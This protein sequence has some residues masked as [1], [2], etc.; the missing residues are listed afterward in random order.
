MF[1]KRVAGKCWRL[2]FAVFLLESFAVVAFAQQDITKGGLAGTVTDA[3]GG[4]VA[5]ATV[6]IDGQ[7][8][9]RK[10]T[11]GAGGQFEAS[12]LAPG[13]YIVKAEATGFKSISIPSVT[14]FVGKTATLKLTLQVGDVSEVIQVTAGEAAVDLSS[15][16]VSSNLNDQ[17][18]ENLPLQRS[19]T[20]LFYLAPGVA[21]G[22]GT[23]VNNPSISGASGL[24]N[25]YVADGVNITDSAFGGLGVFS[26]SYGS[27]GTAI[28]TTFIQE[29]Q[30]KTGGFEPR[31]GQAEGG[32]I[33]IITKSGTNEYHGDVF[34]YIQPKSFEANRRQRDTGAVNKVGEVLHPELYEAGGDFSGPVPG[35][36]NR[37]FFF[38]SYD[39]TVNRTIVLG[40]EGSGL[41]NILGETVQRTVTHNYSAKVDYNLGS[42]HQFNFSIFGDPT[43]SNKAPFASLNIDNTTANSK[44]NYGTRNL[45]GRYNG[46]LSSTW[47]L[48]ASFSYGHNYFTESGFDNFNQI[49]DRTQAARGNFTAI[50]RGFI[51]PTTGDTYRTTWD[52]SKI[53]NFLG[54]H[55]VGLGYQYQ[56]AYYAGTRDRSGPKF[57][58]PSTNAD[59][60][61]VV[62]PAAA[63]ETTN[64]AFSLR[65][66]PGSCTLCP[67]MNIP[68]VGDARVFLRQD[69]GEFGVPSFTTR[70]N[71]HTAYVQDTWRVNRYV[72][73]LAGYRWEQE[74]IIG[75][76]GPE[77]GL[78]NRFTFNDNWSPR[79]GVTVDPLGHGKTKVY[80]NFGRFHEYLPL[81]V[82]ERS[83]SAE[84]D[85]IGAR[86][87][88]QFTIDASGNRRAVINQFGTVNPVVDAAHLLNGSPNGTGGGIFISSQDA[89][90]P[91]LAG[92]RLGFVQEHMIGF[93]HQLPH[94]LVV[95]V[96]Y[97]DRR[98][99]RI[100]EDA[101]IISPEG[102][103]VFN[104]FFFIGNISSKTD[105]GT[106][107]IPI[108]F[109]TGSP[110]P[111][112]CDPSLV[113]AVEDRNGNSL[114][115]VC[116]PANGV[117]GKPAG[118]NF[119][120]GVPDG[121]VDPSRKYQAVEFEVNKRFSNN[122][123]MLANY[124]VGRLRGNYEGHFRN[125]N[126]QSDPGISSLF[127]FTAGEFNL[128][129]DQFAVGPLNTDRRHIANI[130]GSYALTKSV[131]PEK[132]H[133]FN[134]LNLG[135]VFH[136]ESGTPNSELAAHP[137]YLNAGEVPLG[138][139]GK[140][141]RT[142]TFV[143]VDLH[144]DY[145]I[146]LNYER[147]KV[148]VIG[149]IFNVTNNRMVRQINQTVE[150]TFN[151]PNPD[152][153][154]PVAF[155]PPVSFRLGL[156]LEF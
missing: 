12:N 88:P 59:G 108:K 8:D 150:S 56:R 58:I 102:A 89:E 140:L 85:F 61:F 35:L 104:Q 54:S 21:S 141:G 81:D 16:A 142:S 40:A 32:I 65:L 48:S 13:S 7:I 147:M 136:V 91:I 47:T 111:A 80:Y 82:A 100:I 25:L 125:D 138:G 76:P 74:Q 22:G 51:E 132:Y 97:I 38:G 86:F 41:R 31:Y 116:Y 92:T 117:N 124:R 37:M 78:R 115:N 112:Q 5:G 55:T 144:A 20:S 63:G 99:K 133:A 27:L 155:A 110:V 49:V 29:V 62:D 42:R 121:F 146:P 101:A 127:D 95:S 130:Y 84:K 33:N 73:F 67:F 139:R 18:Y 90:N 98:L 64:V 148:V 36:K 128:L 50:G 87:A 17:L 34:S 2:I 77:T 72:Q 118:F 152:F 43:R 143:R 3:S 71:Y 156:K 134:G 131:L 15:T 28:N 46:Q 53:V 113:V 11:T 126:G 137:V 1:N 52:T 24:D 79:F 106:N 9:H 60:T 39:P 44:L 122:W 154:K 96:R 23:G 145:R 151:Q 83:L 10:L 135:S 30:V 120:D 68:G 93:E 75:S 69:R 123:Q 129:G 45:A 26:R 107:P 114:G 149:D 19:V 14:V 94:N 6:T 119:P 4:V 153:K 66:A 105:A 109:A 57:V 103:N 70:S